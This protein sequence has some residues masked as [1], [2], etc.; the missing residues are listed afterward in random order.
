MRERANVLCLGAIH[1]LHYVDIH[2][3][4]QRPRY[5]S[6]AMRWKLILCSKMGITIHT[7]T[8]QCQWK[9]IKWNWKSQTATKICVESR[10]M[11]AVESA[12]DQSK[13]E[14]VTVNRN[15]QF[16]KQIYRIYNCDLSVYENA[17]RASSVYWFTRS[18]N[19]CRDS[20]VF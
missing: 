5:S 17:I 3:S 10:N 6:G 13:K 14:Y 19:I 9:K 15:K 16:Q 11:N 8:A 4:K 12:E 2:I 1:Q 18:I 7:H 20:A